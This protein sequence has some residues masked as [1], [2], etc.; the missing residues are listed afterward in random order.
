MKK[1]FFAAMLAL[2]FLFM[3]INVFAVGEVTLSGEEI[4][5][6]AVNEIISGKMDLNP[7]R[8]INLLIKS[9]FSEISETE[10]ILKSI[11]LI[12]TASGLLRI[13]SDSFGES[14]SADAAF[15]ACFLLMAVSCVEIFSKT[16][17]YGVEIIH[18]LCDFITKFEPL[19]IG[20]LVS[21][22]AVTQAAA[23]HPVITSGV[24]ILTL[25]IDKCILPLTYFSAALA[26]VN[27]IGNHIEI[28]TLN[29]LINS[30]SR[31]LLSGVLTL[32]SA[33]LALYGFGTS[34]FGTVTAKGIKFAVGS[35]VPVVG[36][37]LS[38]T[39]DNVLA[40][41]NLLKNSVGTAGMIAIISTVFVPSLKIW[42]MMMLLKITAA[43]IEPFSDKRI[44]NLMLAVGDA[45]NMIFSMVITSGMLFVI[46]IGIILASTG[47]AI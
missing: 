27:N 42:V 32:F 38:D 41:T 31:W 47:I 35:L 43:V 23:F 11:L 12:A 30:A 34:A 4:Y 22:G 9:I 15:F 3:E 44:T 46:S 37:L 26:I 21:C 13:I 1:M 5:N 24:Y 2:L 25:F 19:F 33:V 18:T 39:V 10:G 36:G 17:G 8:L 16:V 14:G 29:K 40:G 20:M 7:I 28:G 45:V 6:N